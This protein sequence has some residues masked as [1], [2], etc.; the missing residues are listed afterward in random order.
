MK[1]TIREEVEKYVIH[2]DLIN[3]NTLVECVLDE[4]DQVTVSIRHVEG[5]KIV[6]QILARISLVQYTDYF[7]ELFEMN[8]FRDSI[9]IFKKEGEGFQLDRI[10]DLKD[11]R[12]TSD[13]YKDLMYKRKFPNKQLTKELIKK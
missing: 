5:N 9:A 7:Q 11:Y 4:E 12:F 2:A 6:E 1:K 13:E 10:F 8:E 3:D